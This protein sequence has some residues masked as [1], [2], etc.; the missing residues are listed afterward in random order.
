MRKILGRLVAA[1]TLLLLGWIAIGGAMIAL[2]GPVHPRGEFVDIGGR[3]MR[4]VCAGPAT[5]RPTVVMEAGAFGLAADFGSVQEA[6]SAQGVRSCAY[7][8]AGLGWSDPGPAPRDS[9]A[10][11]SDLEALLKAKGENGPFILMGHS[12]AGLHVRLFAARNASRVRGLVLVEATTPEALD[13]V[14][15]Q[16]FVKAFVSI[17]NAA[18]VVASLGVLK[19][20]TRG[21]DRIGLPPAA[22]AEKRRAFG[23]G[24][25]NRTAAA[26]VRNWMTSAKEAGA[27]AAFDPDWPVAVIVAGSRGETIDSPRGAPAKAAKR[28]SFEVVKEA[29]HASVLGAA[30]NG[31][32][33]RGVQF[34]LA[35]AAP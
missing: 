4:I 12:M 10:I 20:L 8:R 27:A 26:E 31:A 14:G 7:D 5:S 17:S 16:R 15:T 28:G 18:A 21:A 29:G 25:H 3:K 24:R 30:M 6:L 1:A 2:A 32:V 23:S 33:V 34:V 22:G 9:L 13:S 19:P 35:H 11:V